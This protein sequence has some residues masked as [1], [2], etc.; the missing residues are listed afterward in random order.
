MNRRNFLQTGLL[1]TASTLVAN[2]IVGS[3]SNIVNTIDNNS[4]TIV[5][6][7][8][9]GMYGKDAMFVLGYLVVEELQKSVIEDQFKYYRQQNDFNAKLT[10]RS[11]NKNKLSLAKA[12]INNFAKSQ[13]MRFCAR[14]IN[15]SSIED[16]SFIQSA[17]FGKLA[18]EKLEI[19]KQLYKIGDLSGAT[20]LMKSQSPYGPSAYFKDQLSVAVD[21]K[22]NTNAIYT[23][24]SE[25]LQL[26]GLLTGSVRASLLKTT[27]DPV[28]NEINEYL[29]T[30]LNLKEITTNALDNKKFI[31]F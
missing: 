10:Y 29:L 7:A 15:N 2:D 19:Y 25:L 8:E 18:I 30:S 26:A 21:D 31:V 13:S 22:V 24:S 12:M 5:Y 16:E 27:K 14:V 28:K 3:P 1:A 23:M 20:L 11:N 9:S 6:A 4:N 17:S